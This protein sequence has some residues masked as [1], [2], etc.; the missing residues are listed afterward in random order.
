MEKVLKLYKYIDG[1]NDTPFPNVEYQA[2]VSDFRYDVKR[3]GGAPIITCTVMHTLCLDKL[4]SENVYA[5]FNGE[6][7]F[8]KQIPTSSY[9]N[10]DSRYK[11]ELELV[12]ERFVL[13]NVYFYDVVDSSENNDKPVSNSSKFSFFGDINEFASRLN[14]SLQYS[15]VDYSVVVDDGISSEAK[16]VSFQDQFFSGA[17]QEG[18]NTYNVPFYFEGKVIHFGYTNNAITHTFKYG[19]D[20]SL[21]SIQKQ[22]ANYKVVNRVTGVGSADNIPYYYPNDYESKEEVEA[23]GGTWINPQTNLMPSI[24]RESLGKERFYEA[25][26]NAYQIPGSDEYYEFENP[27][28][29]GKP[30][31]HIVNFDYIKPTIKGITNAE[32]LRIDMFKE[33]AYDANDN[34]EVDEEGNY[35]HPYFFAKLRKFD[36]EHGF[37]LFDHAIDEQEMVISVTSGSC[38]ACEFAIGVD[39]TTQKN[40][41][42]VDDKGNL[43]RGEDGNV[44]V[45]G[46][47]Q[48]AQNN[49]Q[50]NEVWIALKK[51][52][53]TFGVVM[54]NASKNYRPSTN[55]TFVILHIDLP[56]AYILAAEDKLKEELIKYMSLN[57]SEKFNF[58][59][60]FSRI[61]FAENPKILEQLNENAR[62]QIEYDNTNYELYISSYSYSISSDKPL[63]EIRVE[64][65]DTLT[66]SQNALQTAISEIKSEIISSGG[67][68]NV[69]PND[70]L[71]LGLKYFL[72][73]DTDDR[74]PYKLNVGDKFTAEK[75]IQIGESFIPGILTGSGGYFDEYA[76]GEVESLIIR[77]FLEVPELRFNRVQ[78]T[79]GDKWNAP[80][81]GVI[82]RVVPDS[83]TTGTAWLKLEEGEYGAIAVGDICMGIFHSMTASENATEDADD[84]R[85]NF[86]F[87]GFYTCY[88]TI[89]EITGKDN[90][91]F[92]YQMRPV[93][94]RWKLTYHPSE[95][96]TFVCY[97]SFTR[98]D[99]QTSV[100][101]TR[102]Y[103]RLLKNQNTWEISASNIAMQYGNMENMSIHG[104]DMTGYSI[105][106]NNIYMTGTMKQI[107]PDGTPVLVA[108]DRGYWVSGTTYAYYDRVSHN[109]S[110]WLCVNENGTN[111]EPK[112]GDSSWLCQVESGSSIQAEGRWETKNTP[113]PANSIVT[114]A[115]KVWISNK[116]TSNPPFG[117]YTD[118]DGNR[119]TY[120]DGGYILVET[121]IQSEDWDLLLD[122]PQLTDGKDGESLQ[123]RYSSDKSNWHST[124]VEG[125]VWMQQRVGEG[126]VWSDAIRIVGEAGNAGKDG[127]YYDYQFAVNGSLDIAPTIGWQD[128]PPSVGIGQ[129]LWMRT[130]FVDPNSAEENPWSTARIGGEK[131]RGVETVTEYYAVSASNSEA[132][133][134]WVK[135]KIPELTE[136]LKYLWNYEEIRYTDTEV[137][138]TTPIV[139]GMF[140]KD[141]NGIKSV[142]EYYGLSDDPDVQPTKWYTDMLI[143]TQQVRYLWNKVVTEYTQSGT[144]ETIRII[145]IYGEKGDSVSSCGEWMT[146][147]A[148]PALG[149]VTMG[150]RT[151]LA[152]AATTN[153]PLWCW[154][155]KD[156]NRL[157]FSASEYILTGEL[158]TS[159]YEMLVQS[160]K[161]GRDGISH[162]YIYCHAENRPVTPSSV[163]LD[164]YIP[165]GWHDDPMGV[166]ESMPYEW[167][168]LRTKRE[169]IWSEYSTPALW[170]KFGKDGIDGLQGLQGEK[171]EQGIPG[172]DGA[173]GQTSYFHV[174]YAD[175]ANGTNMNESGGD[176]I[177][178]Y[179]DF[180]KEDSTDPKKYTW[181]KTKGVQGEK[182]D[183][184]IPGTNGENG[185]TSYLHIAYANSADGTEGFSVSDSE[186]KF[187]IG[188]YTDFFQADSTDPSKYHW[189]LIK[190]EDGKDGAGFTLMG[191][192]KSGVTMP[193]MGVVSMGGSCFASLIATNNPPLWCWTDKDGN[194]L[195]MKDGSYLLTGESN[196]SEFQLWSVSGEPGEQGPQGIPGVAGADGKTFYTWIRYADDDK[197]SGISNSPAGKAYIG[198]AY[199]KPSADES[200]NPSDYKWAKIEGEQGVP[201]D[202]GADG[203]QY[204]TWIAYS[205][206]ANGSGMYQQ[207]KDSTKYIGIAVNKTTPTE[208]TDPSEYTWSLFRGAQGPQGEKGADGPK[209]DKGDKGDP[210][211]QGIQGCIV[212]DSEWV[213]GTQ[214]HNDEAL[215]S[216]TRYIDVVLVRNDS[217]ATGWDAYKCKVTHTSTAATAPG[218]TTY[219]EEFGTNVTSIFTSLIIAKNAKIRF[220]A[221]NQLVMQKSNGTVTAGLSGSE[222]GDKTR[223]WAGSDIPDNAPFS[224]NEEGV[225]T[226]TKFRTARSGL[227]LEAENGL[228]RVFG[229]L[230]KN[231]EFG[232]NEEGLAVMRYYDND[233][234]LLYDL[235]P[236][237]ISSVKRANDTWNTKRLTYLG[238]DTS[239]LFGSYWQ[240]AKNPFYNT[241]EDKYQFLSGFIGNA[242]NDLNNNRKLFNSKSKTDLN[243]QSNVIPEG[244]YCDTLPQNITE[245]ARL[246]YPS[247]DGVLPDDMNDAN[248]VFDAYQPIYVT[249]VFYVLDGLVFNR[250]NVY[251]NL[252]QSGES[253]VI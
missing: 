165:S 123:V 169:G 136:T 49:T 144:D 184:G 217:A 212:R 176:Y 149:I 135:D 70:I 106:L 160:G 146:G 98:T 143:P 236:T 206:N 101:T 75:G 205:D 208:G 228:I 50:E 3:M 57:N 245:I 132:P 130:R 6:R 250:M 83:A 84:S 230:A 47:P 124:F 35:L 45:S 53:D 197:G 80:G 105:Y 10:T 237:G 139:V 26:N 65:S 170:A 232:V 104:L 72:R 214:Y 174:K 96:M 115:D 56:K 127:I 102:T 113:Y 244:W 207:P 150:S 23:N 142:T 192:W 13:D 248:P 46:T 110:L 79:L 116:E 36:G 153:P 231:I 182:G 215:T 39:E 29:E 158:N 223:I 222:E 40:P 193:V 93:S 8:I 89:T 209:G 43:K 234:V 133:T 24:Y 140:S 247:L 196:T 252:L 11:H 66:I 161:D 213:L 253:G 88:F 41:V 74:T 198:F 48:D 119:L 168:C 240:K 204:Y 99:R 225:T 30:K 218:N 249:A 202:K 221:G 32:G 134:E 16:M 52:I 34:D 117:T 20:E 126:S 177:G 194:R 200:N 37:N 94:D 107:K 122:A 183:Q 251:Y 201:G 95:A 2:V 166:T 33:F 91:Q 242:Y 199:N 173:N 175:D 100:Y 162:E 190:G 14:Q 58:S 111:S 22:N 120:N 81:A 62:I 178:T 82:E 78:V 63:P 159:E 129:Y 125:D 69:R 64:L 203:T 233:G 114:F 216:G 137:T 86:Q 229:S 187:F 157:V 87:A 17:I 151:W 171:G 239:E 60:S 1:S 12:S 97:G 112:K 19:Q 128:T 67:S 220:L 141:G 179:V 154:T 246:Q 73:K 103:T 109:G 148:V 38:G 145:A 61:F 25:L 227:R 118:K 191:Q 42:Q 31:E 219:W 7:F 155:D 131:G 172:Q 71:K 5:Y 241:G 138:T 235:G 55:D 163:Q 156:G 27:Y 59:I 189:T 211:Q 188:Q 195:I 224:V 9:N 92:R 28:I 15:N 152:N 21:L 243:G 54:P 210:G 186:G 108:N 185:Q 77:R 90:K 121:L 85:G 51:D 180:T 147:L 68:G 44:I 238:V 18:Y 164:D 76:N 181:V 226:S 4:W 167:V